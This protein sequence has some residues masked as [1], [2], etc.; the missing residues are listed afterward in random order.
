MHAERQ[1]KP[2]GWTTPLLRTPKLFIDLAEIEPHGY[3]SIHYH[4]HQSNEFIVLHGTLLLRDYGWA[5]DILD[6]G[7]WGPGGNDALTRWIGDLQPN[8]SRYKFGA[9]RVHQFE[10]GAQ[11]VTCLELYRPALPEG[12]MTGQ[13]IVRLT[14]AGGIRIQGPEPEHPSD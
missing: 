6:H 1:R 9:E 4:K 14:P 13:D 12:V 11:P 5:G 3:C 10:A 2:W 7:I 8:P